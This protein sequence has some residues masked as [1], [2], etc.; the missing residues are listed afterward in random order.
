MTQMR[1]RRRGA[2]NVTKPQHTPCQ[3]PLQVTRPIWTPM[4]FVAFRSREERGGPVPAAREPIPCG[5]SPPKDVNVSPR[6][7]GELVVVAN[8]LPVTCN[9]DGDWVTSPG[10]LVS[11][12]RPVLAERGARGSAP[13]PRTT[14][15]PPPRSTGSVS[16]RCA[17]M[18]RSTTATT[19][20]SPT[21]PCGRSTT[22][23]SANR[24]SIGRSGGRTTRPS[25]P[26][27]PTPSRRWRVGTRWCGCTTTTCS[28][29]R[30]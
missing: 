30:G 28:S 18:N 29:S 4:N 27:S 22:M 16:Y 24:C 26:T 19:R 14:R 7:H 17:S 9:D 6:E 21:P 15:S 13:S 3:G 8:R 12:L 10:G 23:P 1:V 5:C 11:A 2:G 20:A 25:T